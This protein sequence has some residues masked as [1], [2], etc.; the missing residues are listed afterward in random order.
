MSSCDLSDANPSGDLRLDGVARFL[1]DVATEDWEDTRNISDTWSC[2]GRGSPGARS[3][4]RMSRAPRAARPGVRARAPPG[5]SGERTSLQMARSSSK[6]RCSGCRL[7]PRV[8]PCA[9]NSRSWTC[10]ERRPMDARSR[11]ASRWETWSPGP[12]PAV[13]PSSNG[14]GRGGSRQQRG[15]VASRQRGRRRAGREV[16]VI[17]HGPVESGHEVRLV[18]RPGRDVATR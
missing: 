7:I 12:E 17:H 11:G 13:A 9:S 10:T 14:P 8:I 1:Q 18:H 6:Q 2:A 5:L 3:W 16:E 4:P 15:G